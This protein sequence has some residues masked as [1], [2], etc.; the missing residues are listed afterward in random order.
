MLIGPNLGPKGG[1][2]G[3]GQ[4]RGLHRRWPAGKLF[5][6]APEAR[7]CAKARRENPPL[8]G[9]TR[10]GGQ[11]ESLPPSRVALSGVG[12]VRCGVPACFA[13]GP[14]V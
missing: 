12:V 3:N 5:G 7:T 9:L 14:V 11:R 13:R 8:P 4:T 6:A 10:L 1:E 2:F